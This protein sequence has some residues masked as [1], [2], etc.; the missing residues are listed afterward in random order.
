MT[1]KPE[2][3]LKSFHEK[4]GNP[5]NR[6]LARDAVKWDL[7]NSVRFSFPEGAATE[8]IALRWLHFMGNHRAKGVG[9]LE[10]AAFEPRTLINQ[11]CGTPP[12]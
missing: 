11:G 12:N 3:I 8:Q 5:T 2:V 10:Q 6:D 4:A 1:G 9:F 7:W